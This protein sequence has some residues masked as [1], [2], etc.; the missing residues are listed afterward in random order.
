MWQQTT[1]RAQWNL[2]FSFSFAMPNK[3]IEKMKT[4][5]THTHTLSMFSVFSPFL[6]NVNHKKI[7]FIVTI[8]SK[9]LFMAMIRWKRGKSIHNGI[10]ESAYEQ[11]E[12]NKRQTEIFCCE[13]IRDG[14]VECNI[15][16]IF[17]H[18]QRK[19]AL[20]P[21]SYIY[22]G[23]HFDR[24]KRFVPE[25]IL[26]SLQLIAQKVEPLNHKLFA[27]KYFT[28]PKHN[29]NFQQYLCCSVACTFH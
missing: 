10:N 13:C 29:Q 20:K 19:I 15:E 5:H 21:I 23:I 1:G 11:I 26:F 18:R 12:M 16:C 8:I 9:I 6:R 24:D 4:K 3:G 25:A 28:E 22:L 14:D 27:I 2:R 7:W 17:G